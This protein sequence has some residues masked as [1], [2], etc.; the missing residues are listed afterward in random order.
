M[1]SSVMIKAKITPKATAVGIMR[2]LE[3]PRFIAFY[4]VAAWGS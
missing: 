3:V 4:A 1:L 2:S